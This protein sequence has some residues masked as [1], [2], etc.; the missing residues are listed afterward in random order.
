MA[1]NMIFAWLQEQVPLEWLFS[2]IRKPNLDLIEEIY[3]LDKVLSARFSSSLGEG[4]IVTHATNLYFTCLRSQY[5]GGW[6][7]L[8]KPKP[9]KP[10][11]NKP[12]PMDWVP[13][14]PAIN[15]WSREITL[16]KE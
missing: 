3:V 6:L 5:P 9:N 11:P 14:M 1:F 15:H 4:H 13:E 12:E 10:E 2:W 16:L 7:R 8:N